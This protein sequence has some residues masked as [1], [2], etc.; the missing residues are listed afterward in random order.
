MEQ[1]Q[2][3]SQ[4]DSSSIPENSQIK[5]SERFEGLASEL[6]QKRPDLNRNSL[7]ELVRQKKSKVGG[8][9]LTDQGALFLV[10]A[11]LGVALKPLINSKTNLPSIGEQRRDL[12]LT[13]RVLSI[14][15][16][17]IFTRKGD[18]TVGF[19]GRIVLYD[20]VSMKTFSIWNKDVFFRALQLNVHPGDAVRISGAYTNKSLDTSSNS[21][22]LSEQSEI[23][24]LE[25]DVD[26]AK[27][28]PPILEK[29]IDVGQV[30]SSSL[31]SALIVKGRIA[32]TIRSSEFT[33]KDGTRSRYVSFS[34]ASTIAGIEGKTN[35]REIRV[36][37]WNNSNPVFEK[38][39]FG[40]TVTLLNVRTRE[41]DFSGI[42][43]IELH[44]NETTH[45]L[46][47]WDHSKIWLE[48]EF[49]LVSKQLPKSERDDASDSAT[50][51]ERV[52]P[53]IARILSIGQERVT[54]KASISSCHLLLNDSSKTKISVTALN[55][56]CNEAAKLQIDDVIVCRPD[57]FDQIGLRATCSKKASLLKVKP[58]RND[59]PKSRSLILKLDKLEPNSIASVDCMVLSVSPP[60][61]VQTKEGILKRSEATVADPTG[62]IKLYAWRGLAKQLETLA[63]GTRLILH[64]AEVQSREGKKFL[65]FKNY[66]RIEILSS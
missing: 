11:D 32:N 53:F 24:K 61:D 63:P 52:S 59:I 26:L 36:V 1:Q 30:D 64:A 50:I 6:I 15:S 66:T 58:E 22:S 29:T 12:S 55:D 3:E 23:A 39:Q 37:I 10:A 17:K 44:G 41:S 38:L 18:S 19:L 25:G 57:S 35:R 14:G 5:T 2:E 7:F 16:P 56:A 34:L 51:H 47:H 9:F 28:I 43:E 54:D 49:F 31:G 65:V 42:R 13:A 48:S 27:S 62:E 20:S 33:R 46:E 8:G 40:E 45:I 4:K 21:L 60:R